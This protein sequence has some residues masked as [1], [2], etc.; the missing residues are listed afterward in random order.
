M[1]VPQ[2]HRAARACAAPNSASTPRSLDWTARRQRQRRRHREPRRLQ[3]RQRTAAPRPAQC[4]HRTGP[5]VRRFPPRLHRRRRRRAFRRRRQHPPPRRL[6]DARPARRVRVRAGVDAAGARGER[7][8][9][10]VRDRGV[11]QPARPRVV[12]DPA[13]RTGELI[14]ARQTRKRPGIAGPFS[15]TTADATWPTPPS[16]TWPG[17]AACRHRCRARARRGTPAAAP[18]WCA[19][20]ATARRRGAARG[21]RARLRIRRTGCPRR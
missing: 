14:A 9:P 3:R 11:L 10:R 16:P 17:C 12:P 4:A 1:F 5:R 7:V 21:S 2:Q 18:G 15:W 13:L 20:P 6:R 8:R 19:P